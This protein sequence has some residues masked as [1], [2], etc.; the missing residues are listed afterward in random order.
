MAP[1]DDAFEVDLVGYEDN[2]SAKI[3]PGEYIAVVDKATKGLSKEAGNTMITLSF[4]IVSGDYQGSKLIDRLVMID[5]ARWKTV[6]FLQ[7][8]GIPTPEGRKI[9]IQ[10]SQI[11]GR[12]LKITVAEGKPYNGRT[13]SEVMEYNRYAP[14]TDGAVTEAPSETPTPAEVVEPQPAASS[15]NGAPTSPD[16]VSDT[17][18]PVTASVTS[19]GVTAAVED[20]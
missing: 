13:K 19:S 2:R 4:R 17:P 12:K 16:P 5:T 11:L 18:E 1:M 7:A 9:R 14:S 10:F 8:I 6:A 20:L 15:A 3:A